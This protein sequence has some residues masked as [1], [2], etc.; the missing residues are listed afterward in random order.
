M[1]VSLDYWLHNLYKQL[2]SSPQADTIPTWVKRLTLGEA[3]MRINLSVEHIKDVDPT[4]VHE[5]T[6]VAVSLPTAISKIS[7]SGYFH[8]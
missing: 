7:G 1:S 2:Y 3:V 6:F 5:V 4:I 8:M